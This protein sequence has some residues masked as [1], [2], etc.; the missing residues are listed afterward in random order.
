MRATYRGTDKNGFNRQTGY[1]KKLRNGGH[2]S[3]FGSM[4]RAR[5][6][7]AA[8]AVAPQR[9][10]RLVRLA[11]PHPLTFLPALKTAAQMQRSWYTALSRSPASNG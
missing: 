8:C 6:P 3:G 11:L 4:T 5:A 1:G 2:V 7:S 9:M 10:R